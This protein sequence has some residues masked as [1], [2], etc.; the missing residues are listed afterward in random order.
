[1]Q[2]V[3]EVL[4]CAIEVIVLIAHYHMAG[5]LNFLVGEMWDERLKVVNFVSSQNVTLS[6]MNQ[7]D[8]NCEQLRRLFYAICVAL[9]RKV[10]TCE[11]SRIPMPV[12]T[13]AALT[14][15][16]VNVT[17]VEELADVDTIDDFEHVRDACA[18]NSRFSQ[19]SVT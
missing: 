11:K 3:E 13:L 4:N 15:T 17:L 6:R 16:G 12:V 5:V 9:T 18:P 19:L 7:Q 2:I 8:R 1:V 10:P 14:D